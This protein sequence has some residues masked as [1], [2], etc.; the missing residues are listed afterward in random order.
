M[1]V[2]NLNKAPREFYQHQRSLNPTSNCCFKRENVSGSTGKR[3]IHTVRGCGREEGNTSSFWQWLN[4]V[5]T[6]RAHPVS[7]TAFRDFNNKYVLRERVRSLRRHRLENHT[8]GGPIKTWHLAAWTAQ[9]RLTRLQPPGLAEEK[10]KDHPAA[11]QGG[12]WKVTIAT[13]ERDKEIKA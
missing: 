10:R 13:K 9:A 12:G 1:A 8:S 3:S 5:F 6:C 7:Q 11:R 4:S 2:L